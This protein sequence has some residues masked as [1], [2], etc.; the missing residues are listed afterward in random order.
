MVDNLC[1]HIY[2]DKNVHWSM[3]LT[4]MVTV[5]SVSPLIVNVM[6]WQIVQMLRMSQLS[7]VANLKVFVMHDI[8]VNTLL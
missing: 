2:V 1:L 3:R 7:S 4:A 8:A 6:E 5:A